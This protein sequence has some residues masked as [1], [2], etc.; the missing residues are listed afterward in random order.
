M[1]LIEDKIKDRRFTR[2]IWKSLKAGYF[3]FRKYHNNISGT[4]QG[5]II[6]PILANIFMTQLDTFVDELKNEFDRGIKSK[7]SSEAN[8]FHNL[9]TKAKREDNMDEVVKLS[10]ESRKIA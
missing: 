3:E 8:K 6:S 5:S 10:K 4:P 9:I 1:R 2:L 7:A